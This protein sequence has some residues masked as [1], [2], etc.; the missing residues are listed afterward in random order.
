ME[1]MDGGSQQF[2]VLLVE[3]DPDTYELYSDVLASAGFAVVGADNGEDAVRQALEHDPDVIVMDYELRGMDGVA[4]TTLLKANAR[5]ADIPIMMLTGH[6][7]RRQLERARAAGCD[8]FVSKPCPLDQLIGRVQQLI[9]ERAHPRSNELVLVIE[10]DEA[11]RESIAQLLRDEAF[12]VETASNGRE[13]LQL[14]RRTPTLPSVILLD[15]MM[16]VM[17]GW[18][19]RT[20]QLADQRLAGIP[21]VVLSATPDLSRRARD[22]HARAVI[23][24]PFDASHLLDLVTHHP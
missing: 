11:V 16:P 24:K 15:L 1:F 21:V 6:V 20:E 2:R 14:L 19:F 8:A 18:T 13:A 7:A 10:D 9:G 5:T 4:A 12:H 3:D 22:L 23:Q 17:D